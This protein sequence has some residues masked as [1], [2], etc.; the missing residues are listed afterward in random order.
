MSDVHDAE[1]A[2]KLRAEKA[3]QEL[4]FIAK[5][6]KTADNRETFPPARFA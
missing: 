1:A 6:I 4:N 2:A 5:P 3:A